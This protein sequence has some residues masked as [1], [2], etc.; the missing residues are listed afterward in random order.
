[1]SANKIFNPNV[2]TFMLI[3]SSGS[4]KSVALKWDFSPMLFVGGE[5]KPENLPPRILIVCTEDKYNDSGY[6]KQFNDAIS[7]VFTTIQRDVPRIV[8]INFANINTVFEKI[9]E[10]ANN[11]W[12]LFDDLITND[13]KI[14]QRIQGVLNSTARQKNLTFAANV[15]YTTQGTNNSFSYKNLIGNFE[16]IVLFS[17]PS[18]ELDHILQQLKFKKTA[19]NT[20]RIYEQVRDCLAPASYVKSREVDSALVE[21]L[22]LRDLYPYVLIDKTNECVWTV[23][24]TNS[25][26]ESVKFKVY[27]PG[28]KVKQENA[29]AT[30]TKTRSDQ[31]T[32]K[33]VETSA[34]AA[35]DR[36][37]ANT[38]ESNADAVEQDRSREPAVKQRVP[39]SGRSTISHHPAR[40]RRIPTPARY[41]TTSN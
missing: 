40:R 35:D 29:T 36:T 28:E 10:T 21:T 14:L 41:S 6:Q 15:H 13:N 9:S 37:A 19:K 1:M 22:S 16:I 31:D 32:E 12:V 2:K 5:L 17:L 34:A 25:P 4:G 18:T 33:N 11:S 30:R 23:D 20:S 26:G 8:F 3:G 38:A 24:T 27:T 7:V 39:P